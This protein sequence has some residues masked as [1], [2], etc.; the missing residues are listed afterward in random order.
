MHSIR[1][2]ITLMTVGAII[3]AMASAAALGVIAIRKI[4]SRNA[5]SVLLL[6]CET[7]KKNLDFYFE[8]VEKSV[9][10]VSDYVESDLVGLEDDQLQ[11]HL[12]RVSDYFKSLPYNTNGVLTYYYR[13]DPAVSTKAVGFWYVNLDGEG[14]KEHKVTDLTKYN[15]VNSPGL[16]W[17]SVPKSTGSSVWLPPYVTENLDAMVISYNVPVY[18]GKHFVGVIGIE[19]D[20]SAM[21]ND[22]NHITLCDN[23]YAFLDDPEGNLIYHPHM[24]VMSMQTPPELPK[25]LRDDGQYVHYSFDGVEKQ[26]VRLPL[27]NGMR[28]NVAVP[29]REINAD[30]QDWSRRIILS[31]TVIIVVFVI[32][33][34]GF[35]GRMM[36]PLKKLTEVAERAYAGD[37]DCRLDYEGKDE[38]GTLAKSFNKLISY[39]KTH[40]SD[41]RDLAYADALTSLRNKGAFDICIRE[42]QVQID[43]PGDSTEFAICIFDC[44]GLK[45]INDENG[46]DK[47]DLYLKGASAI[48]CEVFDHSPVYRIG[49]DE[50]AAFLQGRDYRDREELMCIFEE[51]CREKRENGKE[52]WERIDVACGMAIYDPREDKNVG[53]VVR[54]ADKLMYD[55]KWRKKKQKEFQNRF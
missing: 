41:L 44:N 52:P 14:F 26:G 21:V 34:A 17:F 2:K 18:L 43:D 32:L 20:Y 38:V 51:K 31:F 54:R 42:A 36:K 33:I 30:W 7:G 40:I 24:D 39:L 25:G 10:S 1:T 11:E 4:G 46:H 19:I 53:D 8:S 23:G 50:F 45:D 35:T 15:P 55:N 12:D 22:V 13:I 28:L 37:F 3:I 48:I 5:D 29:V 27:R 16:V 49:G 9:E 47:G 6:L